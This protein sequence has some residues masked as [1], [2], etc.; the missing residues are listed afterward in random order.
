MTNDLFQRCS[1]SIPSEIRIPPKYCPTR[2]SSFLKTL[3]FWHNNF[4]TC[5]ALVLDL[6]EP[7]KNERDAQ[8]LLLLRDRIKIFLDITEIISNYTCL[9][10]YIEVSEKRTFSIKDAIEIYKK[11]D[12]SRDPAKIYEYFDK[13]F[14]VHPIFMLYQDFLEESKYGIVDLDLSKIPATST[15]VE[16]F[17]SRAR[18][19]D[20][21]TRNFKGKNKIMYFRANYDGARESQ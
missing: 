3:I 16:R 13:R 1:S 19:I 14:L 20:R 8:L 21:K 17:F 2:W 11:I 15:E 12:K 7:R 5:V 9:I 4:D 6:Y 18:N 10:Q